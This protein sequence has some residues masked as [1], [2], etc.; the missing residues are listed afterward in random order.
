MMRI[1]ESTLLS[2]KFQAVK[3][4]AS[5]A[6]PNAVVPRKVWFRF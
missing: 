1:I 6:A 5:H 4:G 3:P 2:C